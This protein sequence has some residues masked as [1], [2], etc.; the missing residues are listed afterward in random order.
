ME[1]RS[2]QSP[3][4]EYM[5]P[6]PYKP[7]ATRPSTSSAISPIVKAPFNTERP[8]IQK[9]TPKEESLTIEYTKEPDKKYKAEA[10]TF[11]P[12]GGKKTRKCKND[13]TFVWLNL[14]FKTEFEKLGW[15][16]LARRKGYDEKVNTYINS[17]RTLCHQ[18]ECKIKDTKD[19]DKKQD[20]ILMHK[21]VK[22]L[23]AHIYK[24]F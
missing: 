23:I 22:I 18:L 20:L 4:G 5:A 21:D 15:M 10:N 8:V 12:F 14:W 3:P 6:I 9:P 17:V 24:Q 7:I 13:A 16:V 1:Y 19:Y 11:K 2:I